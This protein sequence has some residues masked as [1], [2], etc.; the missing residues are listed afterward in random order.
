MSWDYRLCFRLSYAERERSRRTL[1]YTWRPHGCDLSRVDGSAFS[2]WL[3]KRTLLFW[4]DSLSA[5][6]FYS[7]VFLLGPTVVALRDREPSAAAAAVAAAAALDSLAAAHEQP[8]RAHQPCDYE[9]VGN[10][11]GPFTEATLEHGG[12]VLKVLGHVE[13][14]LQLQDTRAEAWWVALWR[15]ADIIVFNPVGHHLRT[16]GGAF[17]GGWYRRL[18]AS[19]LRQMEKYTKPHARLVLRTSNVGHP[20]CEGEAEPLSSRTEAWRRLGGWA[21]RAPTTTPAYFGAPRD[22]AD[23]CEAEPL[24]TPTRTE[25]CLE[26]CAPL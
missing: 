7:L 8:S 1:S 4:G 10:E 15:A 11:G 23:K 9:G 12:R 20:Q 17:V 2:R 19:S 18:V 25:A 26:D 16:L 6:H 3:G 5:Q 14:A 22:G 21:W 13:L 24:R